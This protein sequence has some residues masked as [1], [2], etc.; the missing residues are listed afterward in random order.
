MAKKIH[1]RVLVVA[2]SDPTAGA[3]LQADLKMITALGGYAMTVVSAVTVQDTRRVGGVHPVA[4]EVVAAQ[5]RACL[6]DL[7]AD[8]VKLGMLGSAGVAA[9]VAEVLADYPH[10]PVVADPVLAGSGGGTLLDGPGRRVFLERLLPRLTLLT[11]NLPEAADLTGLEVDDPAGMG[12]AAR[13]LVA[14]GAGAVLVKGG[15]LPGGRVTELLWDGTQ[16]TRWHASRL[17]GGPFHGTGC[18]LASAIAVGLAQG[19]ELAAAVGRARREVRRSL[20]GAL[21]LGQGQKLPVP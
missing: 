9:A 18:R 15:H 7:G 17:A 20:R 13:R 11:P 6:A 19:L 3:G 8:A 21:A 1:G 5:M 12:R 10:L 16:E 4:P 14:L 2:G